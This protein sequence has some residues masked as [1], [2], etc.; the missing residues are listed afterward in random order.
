MRRLKFSSISI[1]KMKNGVRDLVF[2]GTSMATKMINQETQELLAE[3]KWLERVAYSLVRDEDEAKDVAQETY[4]AALN[5]AP[6]EGRALRGWLGRV[7][8]NVVRKNHRGRTRRAAR[9]QATGYIHDTPPSPPARL[10][11]EKQAASVLSEAV[12]RLEEPLRSSVLLRYV[13]DMTIAQ[14]AAEQGVPVGTADSRIREGLKRLRGDL[15]TQADGDAR[16]WLMALC[17]A[18][19]ISE[20]QAASA[21]AIGKTT[22]MKPILISATALAMLVCGYVF[23]SHSK[24]SVQSAAGTTTR[25]QETSTSQSALPNTGNSEVTTYPVSIEGAEIGSHPSASSTG[26]K[27]PSSERPERRFYGV[28]SITSADTDP[29]W[30]SLE[31]KAQLKTCM[32]AMNYMSIRASHVQEL[33]LTLSRQGQSIS[34][35]LDGPFDFRNRQIGVLQLQKNGELQSVAPSEIYAELKKHLPTHDFTFSFSEE[36]IVF[37]LGADSLGEGRPLPTTSPEESIDIATVTESCL[38]EELR[39]VQLGGTQN[40][41]K[42]QLTIRLAPRKQSAAVAVSAETEAI[43]EEGPSRGI[44]NAP[45]VVVAFLDYEDPFS[46]K[47]LAILD[48]VEEHYPTQV[49]IVIRHFPVVNPNSLAAEAAKAAEEQGRFWEMHNLLFA[50][51]KQHAKADLLRYAQQ[52]NLDIPRFQA[53]LEGRDFQSAIE[54]DQDVG[55]S[56]GVPGTPSFFINGDLITGARPASVFYQLIDRQLGK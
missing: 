23:I 46:A 45:I 9:E 12:Q 14:V 54:A 24:S 25:A 26:S 37:V 40:D 6:A 20:T 21:A 39:G 50:N 42:R 49:Q 56:L 19:D 32:F 55:K 43:A 38:E 1:K 33:S 18:L 3:S 44:Q 2:D 28:A 10:L 41:V 7:A 29:S 30:L 31:L 11:Y 13:D 35:A 47:A 16:P 15:D 5:S 53:A 27:V 52:L 4:L 8:T 17:P 22:V 36:G 51:A 34:A 48:G